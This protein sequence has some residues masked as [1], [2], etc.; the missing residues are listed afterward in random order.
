VTFGAA[1]VG[2][3]F[4]MDAWNNVTFAAAEVR[5]P[6]RNLPFALVVGTGAVTVL[7]VLTNLT[8]LSALPLTGVADGATA[9]ARGIQHAAQDRV[10]TAAAAQM[11]GAGGA[12][13]MA[14]LILV[15][16]FGCSNGMLLAGA[17]VYYAMARDGLFFGSAGRLNGRQVPAT[18][19][20]LQAMWI[21]VLCLTGSYTQLIQ[22]VIFP[23]L[24][25]YAITA[26]GIFV[27]R[28]RSPEVPRPYRAWG[29]PVLPALYVVVTG[30]VAVAL[31]ASDNTRAQAIAG[32]VLVLVGVPVYFVW[33]GLAGQ[34][35]AFAGA[36]IGN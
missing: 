12:A 24:V 17:R 19:L 15:S 21:S 23:A 25:F 20:V 22:Y 29:Y 9:T 7:Y 34:P 8:Y 31:L 3:L 6:A 32:L 16:T 4:S 33:R 26:L 36:A 28:R 18:A 1:L 35:E 13:A 27:L 11:F 30:A 5:N 2:A 14:A 10:A